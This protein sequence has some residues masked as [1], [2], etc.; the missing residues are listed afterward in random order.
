MR[1]G[2]KEQ[3]SHSSKYVFGN[4]ILAGSDGICSPLFITDTLNFSPGIGSYQSNSMLQAD[5]EGPS[6]YDCMQVNNSCIIDK[7]PL[8]MA[9]ALFEMQKRGNNNLLG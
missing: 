7:F 4:L 1:V 8:T 2:G 5:I 6:T 9:R 3:Q